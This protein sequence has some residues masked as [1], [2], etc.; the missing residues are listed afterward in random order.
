MK[1]PLKRLLG[2]SGAG[3]LAGAFLVGGPLGVVG[4][5]LLGAVADEVYERASKGSGGASFGADS[6]GTGGATGLKPGQRLLAG[7][8]ITSPS[9]RFLLALTTDGELVLY[10]QSTQAHVWSSE[11]P[12]SGA[13]SAVM[14]KDGNLMLV[15]HDG[16]AVWSSGTSGQPG[17]RLTIHD[18]GQLAVYSSM[19]I[20]IWQSHTA[21][22]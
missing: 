20:P 2:F 11:T 17:S 14:N 21:V 15:A 10:D 12:G 19:G 9:G 5:V 4:G 8:S 7:K 3:G 6:L 16:A 13:A 18:D 1:K 22:G